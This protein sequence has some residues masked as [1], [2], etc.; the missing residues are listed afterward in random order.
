[1][2]KTENIDNRRCKALFDG[3]FGKR[4]TYL[5][6][7]SPNLNCRERGGKDES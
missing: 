6:T 5:P 1:M 7:Y 2:K 4:F 3:N